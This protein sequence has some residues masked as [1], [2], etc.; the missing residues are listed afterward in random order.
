MN[1]SLGEMSLKSGAAGQDEAAKRKFS[2]AGL[3]ES[4]NEEQPFDS[5]LRIGYIMIVM[6]FFGLG[7]WAAVAQIKGAV[8]ASGRVIVES[9]PRL[10]QHF[11]GGVIGEIFVKDGDRVENNALLI[12]L[13]PTELEA[14]QVLVKNRLYENSARVARLAAERDGLEVIAW[15]DLLLDEVGN[16]IVER[17][18]AGQEALFDARKSAGD[19]LVSQLRRRI[20]QLRNQINGNQ[21]LIA[22]NE[23]QL[24]II[25][26]E[27]V[28]LRTLLDKGLIAKSQVLGREREQARLDG[29]IASQGAEISR[30]RNLIGETEVQI[31]QLQR[32]KQEA[33]L[34]EL[35]EAQTEASDLREQ[36]T[37]AAEQRR[38]IDIRAPSSGIVH[39][40]QVSTI[41]GVVSPGQEIMQIIPQDDRLIIEAQVQLQDIDQIYVGQEANVRFSAFS[42]RTTPEVKGLVI[43]QSADSLT[44]PVTGAPFYSVKLQVPPEEMEALNGLQLI[45]GMPAETF[46]QTESRSVLSYLLKPVTDAVSRAGREE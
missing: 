4:K 36:L 24:K 46:M 41:G 1:F 22:A 17:A 15:P 14:N 16:S 7:G 12:R 39:N 34:T 31:L 25:A 21:S 18:M 38:R 42:A 30:I 28:G 13:N 29:D 44:D 45:P 40:M 20:S 26:D 11:D 37:T 27:L 8:L 9:Q 6:L 19:G 32:D 2:F 3:F 35:R 33:V 43:G 5:Y 23:S 10:I